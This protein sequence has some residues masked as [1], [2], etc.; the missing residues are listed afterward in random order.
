MKSG[1]PHVKRSGEEASERGDMP[2]VTNQ[3]PC[4]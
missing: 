3:S 4:E 2:V 1:V